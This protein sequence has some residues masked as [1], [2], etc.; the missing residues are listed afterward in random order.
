[1]GDSRAYRYREGVLSQITRDHSLV[2]EL[3][4]RGE[5]DPDSMLYRQHRNVLTRG[6]GLREDV[7]VDLFELL[8]VATGDLFLLS[9]DG[10]HEVLKEEE[11]RA[12]IEAHGDDLDGLCR[13]FIHEACERGAPD[14]VTV[15]LA[16]VTETSEV[17]LGEQRLTERPRSWSIPLAL[18]ASFALGM[19]LTLFLGRDPVRLESKLEDGRARVEQLLERLDNGAVPPDALRLRLEEIRAALSGD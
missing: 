9:S 12:G 18:F 14:N 11:I 5:L 13:H 2:R 16:K 15:A 7:E 10:L 4:D 6:L 3:A 8:D 19:V 1:M 17:A